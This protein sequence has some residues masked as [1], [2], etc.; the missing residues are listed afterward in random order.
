MRD[1]TRVDNALAA[2]NLYSPED[3]D[4]AP[5]MDGVACGHGAMAAACGVPI[6][7]AIEYLKPN[8]WVNIPM[9]VAALEAG[10]VKNLQRPTSPPWVSFPDTD[11]RAVALVQWKGPWCDAGRPP[12][13][14]AKYRHWVALRRGLVWDI[15]RPEW[16]ESNTW[17]AEVVPL[18]L[19]RRAT[20]WAPYRCI[21]F[22][23]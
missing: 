6:G 13:A 3:V 4:R 21:T 23:V 7:I 16:I 2:L 9:M 10:G 12:Q 8:G 11:R 1:T 5:D 15:N 17:A 22:D 18:L 14:A 19:P 20:A